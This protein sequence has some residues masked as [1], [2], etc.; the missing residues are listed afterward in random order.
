MQLTRVERWMLSNKRN[1]TFLLFAGCL[2]MYGFNASYGQSRSIDSI[3]DENKH[4]W[5]GNKLEE[6]ADYALYEHGR[7]F[8]SCSLLTYCLVLKTY[9]DDYVISPDNPRYRSILEKRIIPLVK[10]RCNNQ[11]VADFRIQNFFQGVHLRYTEAEGFKEYKTGHFDGP[12]LGIRGGQ[13]TDLGVRVFDPFGQVKYRASTNRLEDYVSLNK[14]RKFNAVL[15][16]RY[17]QSKRDELVREGQRKKEDAERVAVMEEATRKQKLEELPRKIESQ[18]AKASNILMLYKK[19]ARPSYDFSGY[20]N[21]V[22]LSSIYSGKFEKYTGDYSPEDFSGAVNIFDRTPLEEKYRMVKILNKLRLPISVA[23]F[24]YHEEYAKACK[25]KSELPLIVWP[26]Q[27]PDVITKNGWGVE[28]GRKKGR[29]YEYSV[30]EPF[31]PSFQTT[32]V[33]M[34]NPFNVFVGSDSKFGLQQTFSEDFQKFLGREGCSSPTVRHFE[35]NL[36]LAEE[37]FLP[38]QVLLPPEKL[39]SQI[40]H[41]EKQ[42][43]QLENQKPKTKTVNAKAKPRAKR[44]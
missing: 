23:Y 25:A 39:E 17:E 13:E 5:L 28:V 16:A 24:A 42:K 8:L 11:T 22:D 15:V 27:E 29:T 14:L 36:F 26:I 12:A 30:R 38:L 20:A 4:R 2:F 21:Q 1:L 41:A 19:G 37:W 7:G 10:K 31:W 44:Q 3:P 34:V 33:F 35:V 43:P 32:H 9:D 40:P 6:T 18:R